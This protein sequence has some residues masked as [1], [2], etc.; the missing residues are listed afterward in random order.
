MTVIRGL[1]LEMLGTPLFVGSFL[2]L[3][4]AQNGSESLTPAPPFLSGAE[5]TSQLNYSCPSNT[6]CSF[7]CSAGDN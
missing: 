4:W 7:V 2:T 6:A 3:S 1:F 5:I